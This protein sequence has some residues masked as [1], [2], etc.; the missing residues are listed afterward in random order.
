M[1]KL[2]RHCRSFFVPHS[3]FILLYRIDKNSKTTTLFPFEIFIFIIRNGKQFY[4]VEKVFPSMIWE[5]HIVLACHSNLV[6][7]CV[8]YLFVPITNRICRGIGRAPMGRDIHKLIGFHS[9]TPQHTH[10]LKYVLIQFPFIFN[11][12]IY[13][14]DNIVSSLAW[15]EK[16]MEILW[17]TSKRR[18]IGIASERR[19]LSNGP[20]TYRNC[21]HYA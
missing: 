6:I 14:R 3:F 13:K 7:K 19:G 18:I 20:F 15:H 8:M 5:N 21:I 4:N 12:F 16:Q 10:T 2:S 1:F 9:P 17:K 11:E